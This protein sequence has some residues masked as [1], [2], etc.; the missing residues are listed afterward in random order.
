MTVSVCLGVCESSLVPILAWMCSWLLSWHRRAQKLLT[1]DESTN[2]WAF[3]SKTN[4]FRNKNSLL[5]FNY[6]HGSPNK[7]IHVFMRVESDNWLDLRIQ[8]TIPSSST[9]YSTLTSY[10]FT[11]EILNRETT[12]CTFIKFY[13]TSNK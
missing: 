8:I 11:S 1:W 9:R 3:F 13:A 6:F 12:L 10:K 2:P 4:F 5:I 7:S